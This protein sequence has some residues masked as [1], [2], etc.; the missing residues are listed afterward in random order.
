MVHL[1]SR[2]TFYE[3]GQQDRLVLLFAVSRRRH[4]P[5]DRRGCKHWPKPRKTGKIKKEAY[6]V[7]CGVPENAATGGEEIKQVKKRWKKILLIAMAVLI[8]ALPAISYYSYTRIRVD[9]TGVNAFARELE[10]TVKRQERFSLAD[11]TD[12]EW[13]AVFVGHPYTTREQM[14]KKVGLT[15]T[16]YSFLGYHI[17]QKTALGRFHMDV[18]EANQLV[19]VKDDRVVLDAILMRNQA[20]L[21]GLEDRISR[22]DAVFDL[23]G[24]QLLRVV[25]R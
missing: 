15:W 3:A 9:N 13:D 22:D 20:D 6:N 2:T 1:T 17:I 5:T 25:D 16:T 8:V 24:S 18:D 14:E 4:W 7:N 19:F 11:V 21:T 10:Q 12:F 23:K